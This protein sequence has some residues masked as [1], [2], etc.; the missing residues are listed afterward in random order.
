MPTLPTPLKEVNLTPFLANQGIFL[1]VPESLKRSKET[2][3]P[4]NDSVISF[5]H[6]FREE[7]REKRPILLLNR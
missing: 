6:F 5:S 4:R 7:L 2:C 1:V 3:Y